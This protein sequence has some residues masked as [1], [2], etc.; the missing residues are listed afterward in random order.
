[1]CRLSSYRDFPLQPSH[2]RA[3]RY[4]QKQRT[5]T[6]WF[7]TT[8]PSCYSP[9]K[10]RIYQSPCSS[11]FYINWHQVGWDH[12]RTDGWGSQEDSPSCIQTCCRQAIGFWY[13]LLPARNKGR[14][15]VCRTYQQTHLRQ[16]VACPRGATIPKNYKSEKSLFQHVS[17]ALQLVQ[18]MRASCTSIPLPQKFPK[19]PGNLSW[20]R[21]EGKRETG[22]GTQFCIDM[23]TIFKGFTLVGE[24]TMHA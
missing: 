12:P 14:S 18:H 8:C 3:N 1:M 19:L 9:R 20:Y 7:V 21:G 11:Q 16:I 10:L 15:I 24:E 23:C 5:K 4:F 13:C 2:R 6:M 22:Q 17:F